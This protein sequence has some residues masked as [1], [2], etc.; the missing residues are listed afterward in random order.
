M[1]A[2]VEEQ[3]VR[4]AEVTVRTLQNNLEDLTAE[5]RVKIKEEQQRKVVGVE[6]AQRDAS[7]KVAGLKG[8][9]EAEKQAIEMLGKKHLAEIITPALAQKEKMILDAR[10]KAVKVRSKAEAEINQL[11]ETLSIINKGGA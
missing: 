7:A 10:A 1:A 6:Q 2:S 5:T 11:K 4:R 9:I 3:E 8:Q